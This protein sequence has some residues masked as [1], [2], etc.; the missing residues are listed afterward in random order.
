MKTII[1]R[2]LMLTIFCC[3]CLIF[4][5]GLNGP[6]PAAGAPEKTV[7]AEEPEEAAVATV[8]IATVYALHPAMIYLDR[9]SVV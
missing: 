5:T 2:F 8:D 4:F 6:D 3:L 7:Q 1:A 9:K